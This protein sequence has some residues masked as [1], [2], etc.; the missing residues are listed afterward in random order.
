MYSEFYSELRKPIK[1]IY[2]NIPFNEIFWR[3]RSIVILI[4]LVVSW[5]LWRVDWWGVKSKGYSI[6]LWGD[7]VL[8]VTVGIERWLSFSEYFLLLQRTPVLWPGHMSGS[9]HPPVIPAPGIQQLWPLCSY[10]LLC[11]CCQ[12]HLIKK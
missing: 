12:P 11:S 6:S 3:R 4:R 8:N 9:S 7:E 2:F 1:I 10:A 5:V